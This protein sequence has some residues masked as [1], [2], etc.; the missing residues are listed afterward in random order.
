MDHMSVG[1]NHLEVMWDS[2][3]KPNG[4]TITWQKIHAYIPM[5]E[6]EC[7]NYAF[8][9]GLIGSRVLMVNNPHDTVWTCKDMR[10]FPI[11]TSKPMGNNVVTL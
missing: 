7:V 5:D 4:L 6:F 1:K 3:H 11:I 9:G 8:T 2:P 10:F